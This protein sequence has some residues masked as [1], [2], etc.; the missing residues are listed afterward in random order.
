MVMAFVHMGFG[1]GLKIWNEHKRGQ[2]KK[3]IYDSVPKIGMLFTTVG[4]LVYLIILK[5]L[6]NFRGAE[7]TA[8]S[9]INSL[10]ELYLG[11][12]ETRTH[13]ILGSMELEKAVGSFLMKLNLCF[14]LVMVFNHTIR[15][16]AEFIFS[17]IYGNR[18]I[19]KRKSGYQKLNDE[20]GEEIESV[21]QQLSEDLE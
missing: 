18:K 5:W 2:Y 16:R 20:F 9:I 8:P 13:S 15:H 1:M 11:W 6:T 14:L 3:I 21:D 4:Y 10:L 12:N 17:G 19:R 7:S